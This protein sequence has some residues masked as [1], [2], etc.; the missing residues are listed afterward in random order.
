MLIYLTLWITWR[1]HLVRITLHHARAANCIWNEYLWL[2]L[3]LLS[4]L[5][6]N[7]SLLEQHPHFSWK[8]FQ[9]THFQFC[10]PLGSIFAGR[11]SNIYPRH[12]HQAIEVPWVFS[13]PFLQLL[14]WN[15]RQCS[16]WKFLLSSQLVSLRILLITCC[17]AAALW[18]LAIWT[19]QCQPY[20]FILW[21]HSD[22]FLHFPRCIIR[23]S[24]CQAG[25]SVPYF[26]LCEC[27]HISIP[28]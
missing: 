7:R 11:V 6:T 13:L 3:A 15:C 20:Y 23:Y 26:S 18:S 5:F 8:C 10:T 14:C 27:K 9:H 17:S 12:S 2:K 28:N 22:T 16:S 25:S 1:V 24:S 19:S 4:L 21:H